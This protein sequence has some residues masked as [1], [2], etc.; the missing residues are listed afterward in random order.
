MLMLVV[1]VGHSQEQTDSTKTID[2]L[3]QLFQT[4]S[5][6]TAAMIRFGSGTDVALNTGQLDF[7]IPLVHWEDP[8]FECPV[9]LRYDSQGFK[10]SQPDNYV[11]RNWFLDYGGVIMREVN[12]VCDDLSNIHIAS[13]APRGFLRTARSG[14]FMPWKVKEDVLEG[15]PEDHVNQFLYDA[16]MSFCDDNT[17]EFSSDIYHFKFGKHSGKFMID[18]NGNV[19]V[20]GDNG[21]I[22]N[23]DI[24]AYKYP[25]PQYDYNSAIVITT[26]DGYEYT[27][28]GNWGSVEFNATSWSL[29]PAEN[30]S[31]NHVTA[32]YLTQVKAPSGRVMTFTYLGN[33]IDAEYHRNPW[34]L[35][36]EHYSKSLLDNGYN[37]YYSFSASPVDYSYVKP[38]LWVNNKM[39]FFQNGTSDLF[40]ENLHKCRNT[41]TKVALIASIHTGDKTIDFEY[42]VRSDKSMY[43]HDLIYTFPRKCGAILKKVSYSG[44]GNITEESVL[45]YR[46]SNDNRMYLKSVSNTIE[47]KHAFEYYD[48]NV[49]PLTM[50]IDFWGYWRGKANPVES[51]I[52]EISDAGGIYASQYVEY[53]L[54][55]VRHPIYN[56]AEAT[57]LKTITYPTGGKTRITYESHDYSSFFIKND[58]TEFKRVLFDDDANHP[59]GGARIKNLAHYDSK[60][61]L[62]SQTSYKYTKLGSDV[63]SSGILEYMPQYHHFWRS[64]DAA[65]QRVYL[66]LYNSDAFNKHEH[67]SPHI[68]YSCV[69]RYNTETYEE[70]KIDPVELQITALS[71]DQTKTSIIEVGNMNTIYNLISTEEEASRWAYSVSADYEGASGGIRIYKLFMNHATP[72]VLVYED[73]VSDSTVKKMFNPLMQFG[74]GTYRVEIWKIGMCTIDFETAYYG[75]TLFDVEGSSVITEFTDHHT[76]PDWYDYSRVFWSD[77]F[78][79]KA[80]A[81][82]YP[83]L[84]DI[85]LKNNFFIP[86]DH[87]IERGKV[88]KET[89]LSASNDTVRT[90]RHEYARSGYDNYGVYARLTPRTSNAVMVGIYSNIVKE[91]F[92]S[93]LPVS[94]VTTEYFP[95]LNIKHSVTESMNYNDNGYLLNRTVDYGNGDHARTDYSY[96]FQNRRP[97]TDRYPGLITEVVNT[98]GYTSAE[99]SHD[100]NDLCQTRTIYS[101]NH[102]GKL[103][104]IADYVEGDLVSK[105]TV[106]RCDTL[107]N[108][109]HI[110]SD[111]GQEYV[112]IWGYEGCYP[113]ARIENVSYDQVCNALGVDPYNFLYVPTQY[114]ERL[115]SLRTQLPEAMVYTYD[116]N[117]TV[118]MAKVTDPSGNTIEYEYDTSKRLTLE[119]LVLDDGRKVIMKRSTY[120]ILNHK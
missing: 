34:K 3:S 39:I 74:A 112:V 61:N 18:F 53:G 69:T 28:G 109:T 96:V 114:R 42:E 24:S 90:V 89:W 76:N 15:N 37:M 6:Q 50:N 105:V 95:D 106:A 62:Q 85:Y 71:E 94:T 75:K 97:E 80:S 88:L 101:Y 43:N 40:N 33:N 44:Y 102:R 113:L 17:Y 12:G 56:P 25:A 23:V 46:Y 119:S 22:Y 87:S 91:R 70:N 117:H 31:E 30:Q 4:V 59:C 99:P 79:T 104:E 21:G 27:F 118:G 9:N 54:D 26:D 60:G 32:F 19:I 11:G 20:S 81:I 68:R 2:Y 98:H 103:S 111:S 36:Y 77:T 63:L 1:Q 82:P 7:S 86:D 65:D 38:S 120:N 73:T 55:E 83:Q 64:Q 93:Y 66:R 5:P 107:G 8:D 116:Y 52:P 57:L 115:E 92:Y 110:I 41:L 45:D 48:G 67:K 47:G 13:E 78:A 51:L 84:D 108:P 72:E 29:S 35:V 16:V 14:K 100:M 10:P 58:S 49:D